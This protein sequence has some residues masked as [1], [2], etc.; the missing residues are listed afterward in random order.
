MESCTISGNLVECCTQAILLCNWNEEAV[1]GHIFRNMVVE[2]NLVLYSGQD[3]WFNSVWEET[4]CDAVVLQGGPCAHDG[5]VQVR[6]NTFAFATGV[7]ILVDRYSE[8]YSHVFTD[9]TYVQTPGGTGLYL[10]DSG[11][12]LTLREGIALLGDD[13][14]VVIEG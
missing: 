2:E 7:L 1:D 13:G 11:T 14:A 3:N 12:A 8:E 9:N 6:N 5:T 10:A 4:F